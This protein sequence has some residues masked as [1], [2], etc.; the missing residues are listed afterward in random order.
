M[1]YQDAAFR[2]SILIVAHPDDEV[3]WFSSILDVVGKIVICFLGAE[4]WPGLGE[5][6]TRSL[7]EHHYRDRI[8]ELGMSQ[9]KAHNKSRWPEPTETDYGLRLDRYPGFDE[10]Y[11]EQAKRLITLLEPYVRDAANVYTHNPWGEYGH[12]DHVQVSRVTSILANKYDTAIWH[13]NYVSNKSISLMWR[14]AN[15]FGRPYFTMPVDRQRSREIA[16]TYYRNGA[17]TWMDDYVWFDS[18]SFVKGPLESH[19]QS[20]TGALFP[21]NF[22]QHPILDVSNIKPIL[23]EIIS[24]AF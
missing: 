17:W 4:H 16:D 8:V 13:G 19:R 1:V 9:K 24:D 12:E 5:A 10:P 3:L 7:A 14:Y 11:Q 18:E 21:V 15:G 22:L 2:D 6:R 23:A 20:G